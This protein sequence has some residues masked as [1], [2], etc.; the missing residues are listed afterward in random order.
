MNDVSAEF[1][2]N[3]KRMVYTTP[4]SYLDLLSAYDTFLSEKRNELQ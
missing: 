4:K 2:E 3:L 1:Y